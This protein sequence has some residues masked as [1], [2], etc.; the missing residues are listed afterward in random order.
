MS[1]VPEEEQ[2]SVAQLQALVNMQLAQFDAMT[3]SIN[4]TLDS[5]E[6]K[7]DELQNRADFLKKQNAEKCKK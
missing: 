6:S 7:I 2:I 4:S 3:Q 1:E 5:F